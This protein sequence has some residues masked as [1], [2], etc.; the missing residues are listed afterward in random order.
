MALRATRVAQQTGLSPF[1][2]VRVHGVGKATGRR[3]F[4]SVRKWMMTLGPSSF[5]SPFGLGFR[6]AVLVETTLRSSHVSDDTVASNA[7]TG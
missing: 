2:L 3:N 4:E 7:A 5:I 6:L 1:R